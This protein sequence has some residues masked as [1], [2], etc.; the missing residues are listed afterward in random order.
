M[1]VGIRTSV[2]MGA[3]ELVSGPPCL[4]VHGCW[5]Q[6]LRDYG[7]MG[8]GIRTSVLRGAWRLVSGTP[9]L[10]VYGN[11]YQDLRA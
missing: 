9:C 8:V 5:Y 1:G 11:W 10:G 7:C 2:I 6:D 4:E 3:W